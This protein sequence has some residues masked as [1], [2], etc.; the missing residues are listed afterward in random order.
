MII[1]GGGTGGHLFP[2]IAVAEAMKERSPDNEILF[3]GTAKGIEGK[4]LPREGWPLSFVQAEGV[5]GRGA[6]AKVRGLMKTFYGTLQSLAIIRSFKP[7]IILGVGGYASAPVLLAGRLAGIKT[8]IHEQNALPGLTNRLLGK[9][10]RKIFLSYAESEKFFPAGKIVVT[11]NPVRKVVLDAF[12]DEAGQEEKKHF[13]LFVMGGSQGARRINEALCEAVTSNKLANIN[14]LKI[15]HQTGQADFER[16]KEAYRT[17]QVEVEI[18]PFINDMGRVY[19]EADLVVCRAGA[20]TITELLAAGKASILVPYPH[21]ADDHQKVNA[22]AIVREGAAVMV[23]DRELS[24][25][26]ITKEVS[27]FCK[28]R[29]KLR[30]MGKSAKVL[31]KGNAAQIICNELEELV[32]A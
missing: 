16:V 1:A 10:A 19:N 12:K 29:K 3:V 15:I 32:A 27:T 21:A 23:L 28:D 5:K 25:E 7:G 20:T 6:I 11:G 22:E 18:E 30:N 17:S 2:A 9:M 14:G 26:R 8:A 31:A 24:A 4:V 13:T